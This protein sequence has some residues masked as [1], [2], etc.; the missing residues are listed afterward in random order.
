MKPVSQLLTI[1]T[2]R[3]L[4]AN[5]KKKTKIKNCRVIEDIFPGEIIINI[6]N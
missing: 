1:T 5:L 3:L 6:L 2:T 4:F